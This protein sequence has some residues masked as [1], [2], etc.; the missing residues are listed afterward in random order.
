M[1]PLF[2]SPQT[3]PAVHTGGL[4]ELAHV[5]VALLLVLG[6]LL[7]LARLVRHARSGGTRTSRQLQ[8]LAQVSLGAKER[9]VLVRVGTVQLLVGVAPGRVSRLHLLAEPVAPPSAPAT[10]AFAATLQGLLRRGLGR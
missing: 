1:N 10:P 2:A 7:I 8:V 9:A 5:I 4:S 6:L 3:V